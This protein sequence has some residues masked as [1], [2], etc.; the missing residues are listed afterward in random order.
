MPLYKYTALD[1][2][3]TVKEGVVE[4]E[5]KCSAA[6]KLMLQG[7]RPLEIKPYKTGSKKRINKPSLFNFQREKITRLE[8]EFF[9]KQITMLL[10]A[11]LSLDGALRVMKNHSQKPAFKEF[12][13]AI[14]RK[15]KEGKSFSQ[16]LADFPYFSPMY[17]NI[18]RAGE[19]GGI[20]PAMLAR[21]AEYQSTFQEL[22]QFII[23]ASVYPLILLIVG[24]VAIVILITTI[25]PRF[26]ILF[27]GMGQQLPAHVAV[28]MG[29]SA[30]VTNH[31]IVVLLS[32]AGPVTLIA[33]YLKQP[34]GKR[35]YQRLSLK[36]PGLKGF[37]CELETTRIFRTLEVLVNNGVHLAIA[38]RI[39]SGIAVNHQFQILLHRATEALKEGQRVSAKLKGGDL[40]PALAVDLLS[41]GEESGR[42][43]EVCGQIA[44]H[45]D[46]QLRSRIKRLIS[47][48]EPVFILVIALI[49]GYVVISMLTVILS[50]NDI[51]G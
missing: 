10:N 17:I 30:F 25:L 18:A 45:Y 13:G 31:Y 43:G 14:E 27:Q 36:L 21:I 46:R 6:R 9:T 44:D 35:F 32:L 23:S 20:L 40:L 26:E 38:L 7:I 2:E 28:M 3:N 24:I 16:A 4:E 37:I 33:W 41:I 11:G 5:D 49:A 19:E 47:L 48:V 29:A 50:I 12:C 22:R 51:A 15:L 39:C 34:E 1:G 42:V 8:I